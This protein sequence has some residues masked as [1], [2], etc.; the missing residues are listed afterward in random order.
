MK[1]LLPLALVALL[2]S[3]LIAHG[4]SAILVRGTGAAPLSV[5]AELLGIQPVTN[6]ATA[7][8][9]LTVAPVEVILIPYVPLLRS[10]NVIYEVPLAPFDLKGTR[11]VPLR[12]LADAFGF[13]IIWDAAAHQVT[14]TNPATKRISKLPITAFDAVTYPGVLL[15]AIQ[16]GDLTT[17]RSLLDRDPTI[18]FYRG[19]WRQPLVEAALGGQDAIV[20]LLLERGC[21]YATPDTWPINSIRDDNLWDPPAF[22]LAAAAM[23]GQAMTVDLLAA[24][25]YYTRPSLFSQQLEMS[26]R[27]E[28]TSCVGKQ[29]DIVLAAFA[30]ADNENEC[31]PPAVTW[32]HDLKADGLSC[33]ARPD[34]P[35]GYGFNAHLSQRNLATLKDPENTVVLADCANANGLLFTEADIDWA[36]HNGKALISFADG[37]VELCTRDPQH[38]LHFADAGWSPTPAG[39]VP[40]ALIPTPPLDATIAAL[41]AGIV[42]GNVEDVRARLDANP[43]L[44]NSPLCVDAEVTPLL[45]A[46]AAGK[47]PIVDLL[48]EK[49]VRVNAATDIVSAALVAGSPEI[50]KLLMAQ[51]QQERNIPQGKEATVKANLQRIRHA[52]SEFQDDTGVLPQCLPDLTV[53]AT[54]G[55]KVGT[56]TVPA[57]SYQGPYLSV[58]D[59]ITGTEIPCNPFAPIDDATV[60]HHWT[61]TPTTGEVKSAVEGTT[62]DGVAYTAL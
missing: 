8:I 52:V 61:Y 37:R 30:Y 18:V 16:A 32:R 29:R 43:A 36:R 25:T 55:T 13:A 6:A 50:V 62:L 20:T 41:T 51:I 7:E 49:G 40:G 2:L 1:A 47:R 19:W 33:P 27:F 46:C 59:G 5:V 44:L 3:T 38:P 14:L 9:T 53:K 56:T 17:V 48:L 35:S 15:T 11:Y 34:L 12:S 26:K 10:G 54:T 4:Q 23:A 57:Y 60:E 21:G 45:L 28:A 58:L 42:A 39:L 24:R 22:A 31:F